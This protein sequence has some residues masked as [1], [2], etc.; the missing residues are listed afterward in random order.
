MAIP[1]GIL[2][3]LG[4]YAQQML[5][6]H[7]LFID[8]PLAA[9]PIHMGAGI[10]GVLAPGFFAHPDFTPASQVGIFYGGGGK[11][12]GWQIA[13]VLIYF[14]WGFGATSILSFWPLSALGV[15][16]VSEEHELA[17][18]DATHHG[19][20]AYDFPQSDDT[21]EKGTSSVSSNTVDA[22]KQLDVASGFDTLNVDVEGEELFT[23]NP[24][25][26]KIMKEHPFSV[27]KGAM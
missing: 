6:E 3:A 12:L 11:Q 24:D 1:V 4:Y 19:G 2:G 17:G 5:F 23:E 20:P 16:R 26:D 18:L 10:M 27:P 21:V 14:L 9:S 13:A 22:S 8:D 7:V 15:L 25:I